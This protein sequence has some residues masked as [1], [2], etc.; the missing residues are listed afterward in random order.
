VTRA[1]RPGGSLTRRLLWVL[2][3]AMSAVALGLGAG[4]TLLIRRVVEQ[5]SDRL[6]G[7]SVQGIAES[8]APERGSVTLDISPST[9]GM[10][11]NDRRDNVYYSVRQGNRLLTGYEDLPA[12]NFSGLRPG[13]KHFAY[14]TF[15]GQRVRIGAEMRQLP[16]MS[17]PVVVEVAQ[18][19]GERDQ[20]ALVMLAALY[21]LEATFV[22]I[23]A[24]L[25]WPA[26]GWSL[27][28]VNR[29]RA[30]L[31]ARPADHANFAPLDLRLAPSELVGLVG[32]FNHLLTRLEGAVAG[33]RQFTADASHQMR[34]PLAILKTHIAVLGRHLSQDHPGASSLADVEG[35]VTRL[36]ALLTRLITLAH[37]EEAVGG[38]I[39]RSRIDLRTVITQVAGDLLPLAARRD[40]TLIVNAEQRPVWVY[41]EPIIA[42]EIF[43]NLLDNAIRYNRPEGTV[44]ISIREQAGS[45]GV[46]VEDDG[47][48]IPE[49]ERKHVFERFYRLPRDQSQPGSGLGLSIVRTLSEALQA[50]VSIDAPPNGRGLRVSVNFQSAV[51]AP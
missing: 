12:V 47:P 45:A 31:D 34:T 15:R 14:A 33:M 38:G 8:L 2:I 5:S 4:G 24:L 46:S 42:V 1:A 3:T 30:E 37:A 49:A 11:E 32:G 40:I 9:L 26:L 13:E 36:E 17:D 43:T 10:L 18:T 6:L 23:A 44:W 20:L 48:G 29:L 28:P 7:A 16:R 39:S 41:A 51:S 35:A 19:V 21:L 22:V 25:V 50:R 27:R